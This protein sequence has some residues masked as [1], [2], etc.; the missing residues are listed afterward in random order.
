MQNFAMEIPVCKNFEADTYLKFDIGELCRILELK[1]DPKKFSLR[2]FGEDLA[3]TT[4]NNIPEDGR[5]I[6]LQELIQY[7]LIIA[8]R[9]RFYPVASEIMRRTTNGQQREFS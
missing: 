4:P 5:E 1:Y 7:Q 2:A 6:K 8:I 3:K 9:T